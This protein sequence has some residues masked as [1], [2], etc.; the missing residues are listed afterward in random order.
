MSFYSINYFGSI[1]IRY[2]FVF[3]ISNLFLILLLFNFLNMYEYG[4]LKV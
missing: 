2:K 3:L 4:S 1:C